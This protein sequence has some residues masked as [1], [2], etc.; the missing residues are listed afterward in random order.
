MKPYYE[1]A[2]IVVFHGD[3]REIGEWLQADVLIT[4]PPYGMAFVSSWTKDS[5]TIANDHDTSTRDA[6]IERWKSR[7]GALVLPPSSGRGRRRVL[8]TPITY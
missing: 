6:V 1:A 2:G 5:P 7:G 3:A 8:P 4:D